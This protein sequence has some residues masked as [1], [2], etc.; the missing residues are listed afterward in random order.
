MKALLNKGISLILTLA[1]VLGLAITG[2]AE[3]V[4]PFIVQMPPEIVIDENGVDCDE[5]TYVTIIF[6]DT[7]DRKVPLSIEVTNGATFAA[8]KNDDIEFKTGNAVRPITSFTY[9]DQNEPT[10]MDV[11]TGICKRGSF[12]YLKV[13]VKAPI[14]AAK[15]NV[16]VKTDST[17]PEMIYRE[18][19]SSPIRVISGLTID[20][21]DLVNDVDK[22]NIVGT[23]T[24]KKAT[25]PANSHVFL[26]IVNED[27]DKPQFLSLGD[28]V[29]FNQPVEQDRYSYLNVK[30]PME[31]DGDVYEDGNYIIRLYLMDKDYNTIGYAEKEIKFVKKPDILQLSIYAPQLGRYESITDPQKGEGVE[32]RGLLVHP[33]FGYLVPDDGHGNHNI[34]S[35]VVMKKLAE[36]QGAKDAKF[37]V[38]TAV[39]VGDPTVKLQEFPAVRTDAS[40][41]ANLRPLTVPP[42]NFEEDGVTR[43]PYISF[44]YT[45]VS[46]NIPVSIYVGLLEPILDPS[47][48]VLD[49]ETREPIVNAKVTLYKENEDGSWSLWVDSTGNQEN[50]QMTNEKGKFRWDVEDGNYDVRVYHPDYVGEGLEYSTLNDPNHGIIQVPPERDDVEILLPKLIEGSSAYVSSDVLGYASK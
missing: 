10:Q 16:I 31:Y 47:G 17:N 24:Y 34:Q 49:A 50:P 21:P 2:S 4:S 29:N 26:E 20:C 22:F 36:A 15:F 13:P 48:W 1:L 44:E 33:G 45:R 39:D 46:D 37:V 35:K 3:E 25:P 14:M 41:N 30:L 19:T 7:S 23:A 42:M 28:N 12:N 9:N 38:H 18:R 8:E 40:F 32:Y 27:P 11:I 5:I 43:V 6:K